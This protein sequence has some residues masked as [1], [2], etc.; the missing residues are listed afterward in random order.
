VI[1]ATVAGSSISS[2]T[3][4][5]PTW[6]GMSKPRA[7]R[8]VFAA[9]SAYWTMQPNWFGFAFLPLRIGRAHELGF[10]E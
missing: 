7:A 5:I 2:G 8:R 4:P 1:S 10:V 6:G 9:S 3:L